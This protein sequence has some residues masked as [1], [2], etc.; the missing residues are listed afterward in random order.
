M[1]I[2]KTKNNIVDQNK[3]SVKDKI[4]NTLK[5]NDAQPKEAHRSWNFL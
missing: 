5:D 1:I 2:W 4:I 3:E